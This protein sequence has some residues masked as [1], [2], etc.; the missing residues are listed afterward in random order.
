[1]RAPIL[2]AHGVYLKV[3]LR[4]TREVTE[5]A[6]PLDQRFNRTSRSSSDEAMGRDDV[7]VAGKGRLCTTAPSGLLWWRLGVNGC[8]FASHRTTDLELVD[9]GL[10]RRSRCFAPRR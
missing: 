7:L 4:E 6:P 1:M 3:T 10:T 9:H 8:H 2:P 5:S